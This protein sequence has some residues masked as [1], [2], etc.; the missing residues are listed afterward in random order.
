MCSIL[1]YCSPSADSALFEEMLRKTAS[2][3]PDQTSTVKTD[4]GML[5]FNR[6]AIM[7]LSPSGMQPFE[8]DGSFC[9]CNGELYGF[10]PLKKYLEKPKIILRYR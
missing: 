8:K 7:G 9:V 10:R 6:L 5:G 1:T 2:R 3:G 4:E